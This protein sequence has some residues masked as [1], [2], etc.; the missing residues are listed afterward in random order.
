MLSERIL[1]GEESDPLDMESFENE[2]LARAVGYLEERL[3]KKALTQSNWNKSKTARVL[4]LSRQGL[5]KKMKR[6][7]IQKQNIA[8]GEDENS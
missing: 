5:L 6:Y 8:V 1:F 3:L 4:G 7:G 2:P